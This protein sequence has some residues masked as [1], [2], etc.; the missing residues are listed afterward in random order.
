MD[1]KH[2]SCI[3][4]KPRPQALKPPILLVAQDESRLVAVI[5]RCTAFEDEVEEHRRRRTE[6]AEGEEVDEQEVRL[7]RSDFCS[8]FYLGY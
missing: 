6:A 4:T 8:I 1:L 7:E 2:P 3:Q 5:Q